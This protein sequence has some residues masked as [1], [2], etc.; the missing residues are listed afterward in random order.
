M[1]KLM[2]YIGLVLL[3]LPVLGAEVQTEE[4]PSMCSNQATFNASCQDSCGNDFT[5]TGSTQAE[6]DAACEAAAAANSPGSTIDNFSY[7]HFIF[8]TKI[9]FSIFFNIKLTS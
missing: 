1:N 6:A 5:G 4:N 7:N 9:S 3:I 8:N 2:T